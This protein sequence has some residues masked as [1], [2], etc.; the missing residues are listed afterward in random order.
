MNN[1]SLHLPAMRRAGQKTIRYELCL[2]TLIP[3]AGAWERNVRQP[4]KW[5]Q[6]AGNQV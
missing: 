4:F 1:V 3:A 6:G 2:A 5:P